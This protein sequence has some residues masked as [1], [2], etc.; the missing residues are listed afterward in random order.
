MTG[1]R[2]RGQRIADTIERL[3]NDVDC[4]VSTADPDTGAPYLVPLSFYWDGNAMFIAT[5]RA[6]VTGRNLE[7]S[8]NVRL[9][10]GTLRDV[11]LIEGKAEVTPVAGIGPAFG[12]T[13]AAKAGF[14][15]RQS[16]AEY[17]YYRITPVRVQ[18]WHEEPE[19][20]GRTIMKDGAWLHE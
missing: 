13:F 14:D 4:W 15:P 11:V 5:P 1:V 18:A 12:D 6:S 20:T 3:E 9:G 10:L 17:G 2:S 19:L 16:N 7:R 8:G